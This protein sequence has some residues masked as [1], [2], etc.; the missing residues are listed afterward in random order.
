MI[1]VTGATGAVGGLVARRLAELDVT[2][3]LIVRDPNK[4]PTTVRAGDVARASYGDADAMR[5]ALA[6]VSTL[7]LVSASESE[8]RVRQHLTAV[9]AA[10]AAGVQ[11]VVYTSFLGAAP[12][13][14]FTLGRHHWQT[15][16]RIKASGMRYTF[17]RDNLYLDVLPY[18]VGRDRVLR[19]PA[20]DG[21]VGAVARSDVAD[22]AVRALLDEAHD[23]QTYDLT[24]PESLTL[25]EVAARLSAVTGRE[26]TYHPETVSEAYDSRAAYGA[27]DWEVDGWV[28]SYT[29][30]AAGDLDV[31]TDDVRAVAG[32]PPT[33]FDEH[34][35]TRPPVLTRFSDVG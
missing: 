22:V 12:D 21:R 23:G 9:D 16:E 20:G 14:T 17:L 7:L 4:L 3:R 25:H 5:T 33:S 19:G 30:I 31:V 15:E 6:G 34:L 27:P 10:A 28:T 18:F 2:A 24:G 1:A 11:R 29:A 13:C 35:A 32:H 26:I 8:D